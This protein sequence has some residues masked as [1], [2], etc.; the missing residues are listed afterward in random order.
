MTD[1]VIRSRTEE[2]IVFDAPGT[3]QPDS[4]RLLHWPIGYSPDFSDLWSLGEVVIDAQPEV[5]FGH[6]AD[7]C[8]RE[9]DFTGIGDGSAADTE[10]Q[11]LQT[12]SEF[13]YRL[14]GLAV[15]ARVGEC[16]RGSR[17]AWFAQGID[18]GLYQEWLFLARGCRTLVLMGFAARGPAAIAHRE[19]DPAGAQRMV[20]RCLAG[21]KA[22]VERGTGTA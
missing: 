15:R 1:A 17:L 22:Q 21:L 10:P 13:T 14:D 2:E 3:D 18:V 9:R 11:G 4:R 19:A 5:V 16:S 7:I 6:L 12:D 8:R 20:H